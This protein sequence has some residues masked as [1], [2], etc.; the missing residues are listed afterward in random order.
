ML[1]MF[2]KTIRSQACVALE[3]LRSWRTLFHENPSNGRMTRRSTEPPR[4]I[5]PAFKG[6]VLFFDTTNGRHQQ[7]WLLGPYLDAYGSVFWLGGD[8]STQFAKLQTPSHTSKELS[9]SRSSEP[10]KSTELLL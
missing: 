2:T 10:Q 4:A 5:T 8:Y 1:Y 7:F 6:H 9:S 3:L